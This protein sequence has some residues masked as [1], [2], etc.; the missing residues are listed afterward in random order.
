MQYIATHN[1]KCQHLLLRKVKNECVLTNKAICHFSNCED[2]VCAYV[3]TAKMGEVNM[4]VKQSFRLYNVTLLNGCHG[5]SIFTIEHIFYT[6]Q[7]TSS[8]SFFNSSR[9]YH[10]RVSKQ[11]A[12]EC[13]KH[14][15]WWWCGTAFKVWLIKPS[16]PVGPFV[17]TATSISSSKSTN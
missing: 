8:N 14:V 2:W 6:V 1:L 7:C 13:C 15:A 10:S 4:A 9:W 5:F 11:V 16:Q 12:Q 17:Y 3:G